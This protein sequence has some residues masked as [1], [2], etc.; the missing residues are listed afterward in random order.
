MLRELKRWAQRLTAAD[1]WAVTWCPCGSRLTW[2]LNDDLFLEEAVGRAGVPSRGTAAWKKGAEAEAVLLRLHDSPL[3]FGAQ[4]KYLSLSPVSS[5][6]FQV[7]LVEA[8]PA[9]WPPADTIS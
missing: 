3:W 8:G 1:R 4:T 7:P 9:F 2:L 6:L 5:D